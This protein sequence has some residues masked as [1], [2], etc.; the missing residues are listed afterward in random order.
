[1]EE[2]YV[3]EI[4]PKSQDFSRWYIEVIRKAELVDY[5][6]MKGMM[7]IRPYGYAIWEK[8]KE[9]LD[10]RLKETGHVNAY[11]PLFIPESFLKKEAEHVKGFA[12]QVAWVTHGGDEELE[13]RLAVRPTSE[14]IICSMYAK[15][16]KSWR[17]LPVLINQ[18]ANIVRWEKVTRPFLRTTEFLW[19][20]GHT[21]HATE[22]EAEEETLRILSIYKDF[23]E[24]DLAIPVIAG[25][26][27]EREKFAGALRTYSI[28][29]LMADGRALQAGTSHNL[30]QHFSRAFNI[31]YEDKNQNLQYVWQTSWGVSTRLIGAVIMVHGDDSGLRFPPR[32]AP[33]QVVIVPI[34][35]NEWKE[36]IYKK[37]EHIEK[38]L[39]KISVR[40]HFDSREEYTPGW[41]YSDWEMR[42]VPLR[43]EIGPK[44]MEKKQVVL[45]RRDNREKIPVSQDVLIEKISPLLEEIQKSLYNQALNFLKE[46]THN[47][48]NY[49]EFKEIIENKRGFI[50]TFWCGNQDCEDKIKDETGASIRVIS[51][52][53]EEKSEGN[54][55]Y[56]GKKAENLVYFAKA[57]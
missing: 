54:C 14:A 7:V 27:T 32:I 28:E 22:E 29:A 57:Y 30:G 33:I 21:A 23:V 2:R 20:E 37:G 26:K 11:F 45:V 36:K 35:A 47:V 50:K 6:P 19:Q 42:G 44:D 41:K 31:R 40:A 3:K 17:D 51:M 1:M 38:E 53:K 52:E 13:E 4:T 18:W 24:N 56:C 16:I 43:I 8:I 9:L 39:K 48:N 10:R 55:V 12:P 34:P 25:K 46:N 49:E 15:W 5:A